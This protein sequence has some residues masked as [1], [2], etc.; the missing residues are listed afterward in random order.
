MLKDGCRKVIFVLLDACVT[1][2][3]SIDKLKVEIVVTNASELVENGVVDSETIVVP[4]V[5]EQKIHRSDEENSTE[6]VA[7]GF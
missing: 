2:I 5:P 3:V 7:D 1:R 4:I 6:T